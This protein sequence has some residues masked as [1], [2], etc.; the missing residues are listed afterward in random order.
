MRRKGTTESLIRHFTDL[1]PEGRRTACWELKIPLALVVGQ[2]DA[3]SQ[4][5]SMANYLS[6]EGRIRAACNARGC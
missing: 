5:Q 3:L 2:S 4:A 1:T 6:A